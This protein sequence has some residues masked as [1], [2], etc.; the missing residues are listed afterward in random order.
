MDGSSAGDAAEVPPPHWGAPPPISDGTW[1][2]QVSDARCHART[3]SSSV[4]RLARLRDVADELSA[5][6]Q[7]VLSGAVL[8]AVCNGCNP[9]CGTAQ[10]DVIYGTAGC[11]CIFGFQ[12]DDTLYGMQGDDVLIGGNGDDVLYGGDGSDTLYG[13][14]G[15]DMLDGGAASDSLFG[16]QQSDTLYGGEGNDVL[17]G[18]QQGDVLY[19]EEGQRGAPHRTC[20]LPSSPLLQRSAC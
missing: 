5:V 16:G 8:N 2:C 11:D 19:G 4:R 20:L 18:N 14:L 12:G 13:D 17:A 10:S 6:V 15:Y 7:G 9:M 3:R 1:S